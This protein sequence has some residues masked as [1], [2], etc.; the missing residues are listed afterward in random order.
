[1]NHYPLA[2]ASLQ[3]NAPSRLH[4]GASQQ[5]MEMLCF[6]PEELDHR[7]LQWLF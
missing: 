4:G 7:R 1:M 6:F 3:Q 5:R 2:S